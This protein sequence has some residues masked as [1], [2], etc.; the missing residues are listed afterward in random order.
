MKLK[1]I[2]TTVLSLAC[3]LLIYY[4]P[5]RV[6]VVRGSSMYPTLHHGQILIGYKTKNIT[7]NDIVVCNIEGE[8]AIIKRVKYVGGD[9][10]ASLLDL[11][12]T[13]AI[14]LEGYDTKE[15][16]KF[17]KVYGS[18]LTITRVPKKHYYVLGDNTFHS[19][20]SRRF[21]TL[22]FDEIE[23]KILGY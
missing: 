4:R 21:G 9:S 17:K 10:Y 23:Y 19:D 3:L 16:L 14:L 2:L 6:I 5:F 7:R 15:L 12:N 8:D 18:L 13:N 1:F 22:T 20:D 11:K